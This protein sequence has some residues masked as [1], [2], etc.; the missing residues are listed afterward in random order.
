MKKMRYVIFDLDGTLLD[1][2]WVWEKVEDE[3]LQQ[4]GHT[5]DHDLRRRLKVLNVRQS[6]RL[7]QEHF[8]LQMAHH[9]IVDSIT[10]I[11]HE[12]YQRLVEFKAGALEYLLALH[13][14]GV[15]MC[16]ATATERV[17][18]QAVLEKFGAMEYFQFLFTGNEITTGKN[19]PEVFKEC[20]R[21]LGAEPQEVTV[22]ED[23][24]HAM[25]AAKKAG[26]RVVAVY[27]VSSKNDTEAIKA[28]CDEYISSF[29]EKP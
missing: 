21:R 28:L 12:K 24:L 2:M 13:Q 17:N 11:V 7:F 27:D 3:F 10:E 29:A 25:E 9:E 4:I 14:Q 6:A 26:C 20:C 22:F 8:Q 23:S 16:L 5:A 19:D 15:K 1:S 18:A